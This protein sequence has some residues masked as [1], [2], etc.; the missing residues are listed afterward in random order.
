[1]NL[2]RFIA[3]ILSGVRRSA[4]VLAGFHEK[5]HVCQVRRRERR[6]HFRS[7]VVTLLPFALG[8]SADCARCMLRSDKWV[9]QSGSRSFFGNLAWKT[10]PANAVTRTR[11]RRFFFSCCA[12][13]FRFL[14]RD[15]SGIPQGFVD[16]LRA[17]QPVHQYREFSG[18]RH[19]RSFLCVGSSSCGDGQ[20]VA[21]QIAVWPEPAQYVVRTVDQKASQIFIAFLGDPLL[22]ILLA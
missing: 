6:H 4:G 5:A 3:A 9:L 2:R 1:M 7:F 8:V 13:F 10:K 18:D 15:C 11:H 21:A 20:A 16:P 19:D 17:P 22:R 12:F 14:C